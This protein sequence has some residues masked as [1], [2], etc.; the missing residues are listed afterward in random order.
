MTEPVKHRTLRERFIDLFRSG[1]KGWNQSEIRSELR[2][3]LKQVEPLYNYIDDV[4]EEDGYVI[5]CCYSAVPGGQL[6]FHPDGYPMEP[7]T[8][9]IYRRD[10]TL[11]TEGVVT[12]EDRVEVEYVGSFEPV[13]AAAGAAVPKAACSCGGV[14]SPTT[15]AATSQPQGDSMKTKTERITALMANDHNPVKSQA[16]LEA[17]D[18][19]QLT[20]LEAHC[21]AV[22]TQKAA[23]EALLAE[24]TAAETKAAGLQTQLAAASAAQVTPEELT[25]LRALAAAEDAR[26]KAAKVELVAQLKSA[27][28][29]HTEEKLNSLTVAEL[30]DIAAL[31]KIDV[32]PVDFSGRFAA[33]G[34]D[35]KT[36]TY[37]PPDAYAPD[38][39]KMQ[40]GGRSN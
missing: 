37:A 9:K 5:Y 20:S 10:F 15:A 23:A 27:Q 25:R 11:T 12:L 28:S 14:K 6:A 36:D 31:V 3:A 1:T 40:T 7:Y 29:V 24:K 8:T 17:A 38:L 35:S 21:E 26:D 4:W 22:V 39:A 16:M 32:K 34:Q 33:G 2:E 18:D 13:M 19:A 30:R